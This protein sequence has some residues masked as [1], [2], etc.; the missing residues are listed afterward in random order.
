MSHDVSGAVVAGASRQSRITLIGD[1]LK[2]CATYLR[3]AGNDHISAW[4]STLLSRRKFTHP[5]EVAK[6]RQPVRPN[7]RAT[8]YR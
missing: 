6:M 8:S 4:Q 7:P 1:W 5:D 3:A 2:G